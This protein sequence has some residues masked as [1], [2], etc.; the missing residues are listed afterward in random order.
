MLSIL[1]FEC[2][3]HAHFQ[4]EY[5]K[6]NRR[7]KDLEFIIKSDRFYD[8]GSFNAMDGI[9][10]DISFKTKMMRELK[11]FDAKYLLDDIITI[12]QTMKKIKDGEFEMYDDYENYGNYDDY[13]DNYDENLHYEEG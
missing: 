9:K 5:E 7:T 11:Q 8:S 10:R 6:L 3:D 13:E 2:F 4:R 1:D 12:E